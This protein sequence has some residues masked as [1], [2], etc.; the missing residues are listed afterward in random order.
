MDPATIAA[1]GQVLGGLGKMAGQ[2]APAVSHAGT[3]TVMVGGMNVPDYPFSVAQPTFQAGPLSAT[4]KKPETL[5]EKVILGV[6]IALVTG[7]LV[8]TIKR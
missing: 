3:T 2:S 5:T 1:T 7:Y 4:V 8:R 6:G